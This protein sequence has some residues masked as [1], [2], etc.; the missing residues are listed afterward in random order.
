MKILVFEIW[1]D[2]GKDILHV[3][4]SFGHNVILVRPYEGQYLPPFKTWDLL[5]LSGGPMRLNDST[6]SDAR[7][8]TRVMRSVESY[9]AAE[10]PCFGIC[11]GHQILAKILGGKVEDMGRFD[12]GIR[13]I[14]PQNSSLQNIYKPF[15]S[16]VFHRDHVSVLPPDWRSNTCL[17][18]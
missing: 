18:L 3:A 5:V 2:R 16:F 1:D 17:C 14:L 12:V 9:L 13:T 10:H 6:K 8:L 11:L 7:Y 15:Q 4:S